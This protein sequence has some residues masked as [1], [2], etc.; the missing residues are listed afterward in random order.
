MGFEGSNP[1]L[2]E[3]TH[4]QVPARLGVPL[5]LPHSP[6][7]PVLHRALSLTARP[8]HGSRCGVPVRLYSLD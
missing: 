6:F 2:D 3:G 5:L 7:I 1:D 4:E 8:T